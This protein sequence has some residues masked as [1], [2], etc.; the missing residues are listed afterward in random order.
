LQQ[1]DKVDHLSSIR[2]S[3]A[4]PACELTA[5]TAPVPGTHF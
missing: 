2:K 5:A 3:G 1:I 4:S